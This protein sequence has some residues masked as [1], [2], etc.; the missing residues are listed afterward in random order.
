VSRVCITCGQLT[1]RKW[2]DQAVCYGCAG[3]RVAE[4]SALAGGVR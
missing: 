3:V 4:L 2:Y 1:R